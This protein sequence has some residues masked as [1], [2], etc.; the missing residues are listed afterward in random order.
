MG[1]IFIKP[2]S[3]AEA[4]SMVELWVAPNERHKYIGRILVE[5]AKDV[6][7]NY[8]GH[9]LLAPSKPEDTETTRAIYRHLNF[10]SADNDTSTMEYTF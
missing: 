6:I 4:F 8:G 10:C 5:M 2:T 7:R 9:K 3:D 1:S